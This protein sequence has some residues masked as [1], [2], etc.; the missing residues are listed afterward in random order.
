MKK[1]ISF[2][3][4]LSLLFVIS[5][6]ALAA[7]T[8]AAPFDKSQIIYTNHTTENVLSAEAA[9]AYDIYEIDTSAI[10][11]SDVRTS[12]KGAIL[13]ICNYVGTFAASEEHV[14]YLYESTQLPNYLYNYKDNLD[15]GILHNNLSVSYD[16]LD[17]AT[18]SLTYN[19]SILLNKV[20]YYP[21]TDFLI[22]DTTN[23]GGE[24]IAYENFAAGETVSIS[25]E[26]IEQI[27]EYIDEEN[28]DA[29]YADDRLIIDFDEQGNVFIDTV[30]AQP[31]TRA[32]GRIPQRCMH[33]IFS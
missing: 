2:I 33:I 31:H 27:Y 15:V 11:S 24:V 12:P 22:S 3:L 32:S 29:L 7:G 20:I 21:E 5:T 28:W 30:Y 17:G 26:Y 1:V 25:D 23:V 6:S 18:V 19:D 14:A 4:C 13:S 9:A 16:T 10:A 8:S